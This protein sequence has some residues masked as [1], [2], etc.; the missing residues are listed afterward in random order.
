MRIIITGSGG[1]VGRALV[2][3]LAGH[4]DL[5]LIDNRLDGQPGIEGDLCDPATLERAFAGGCDAVVHLAT[6]PGGATELDPLAAKRVNIDATMALVDAAAQ[7]GQRPR[8]LF[9][10]SIAVFGDPLPPLVDDQNSACTAHALWRA[11]GDDR[12]MACYTITARRDLCPVA[13]PAGDRRKAACP[14]WNEI[15][16]HERRVPCV[17]LQGI[18]NAARVR[19]GDDVADVRHPDRA[20][21]GAR[22]DH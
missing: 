9:A 6:V 19:R 1:F 7:A 11:Q 10:S 16:F 12:A 15:S 18:D 20:E 3:E 2:S 8:F 4:H 5:V 14:I 21:P 13:T 17:E 22:A